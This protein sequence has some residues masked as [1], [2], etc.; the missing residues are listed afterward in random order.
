MRRF[1]VKNLAFVVAIN[2]PIRLAY[3]L[4]IDR[5]VQ[6]RVGAESYGTYSPLLSWTVIFSIILDFGITNY[7]SRTVAQNP[8]KLQEL[9][10]TMLSARLLL[11]MAYGAIVTI[12]GFVVGYNSYQML[13]LSGILVFQSLNYMLQFLRS[14]VAAL[15]KFKI[16]GILSIA[17][18]LLMIVVCG[19]L[20]L[21]PGTA[22][23]FKIEWYIL[24]QIGTYG[25]GCI[26][27]FFVLRW[28]HPIRFRFSFHGQTVWRII[29]DTIPYATLIFLMSIYTRLDSPMIER[30]AGG[31]GKIQAAIYA[32]AYRYLDMSNM[33]ALMFAAILLPMFG[34]MLKETQPVNQIVHVCVN[35]L[36]PFSF[37]VA[38][39]GIFF[40]NPIMQ[41]SFKAAKDYPDPLYY[42]HVF[43][44]TMAEFPAFCIMYI[45]STLLTANGSLKTLNKLAIG[46]VVF[47]LGLNLYIIPHY[48]AEGAAVVGC[49]TQWLIALG[50]IVYCIKEIKLK[51][52]VKLVSALVGYLALIVLLAAGVIFIPAPWLVQL[53]VFGLAASL[54]MF[55]FRFIS[56]GEIKKLVGKK[57]GV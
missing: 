35:T 18:R 51:A 49:L 10:P 5:V 29:K 56:V 23:H 3:V 33:F 4:F 14:N 21:Y 42:G 12:T 40:C 28:L 43:R 44:W 16:D 19:A 17:D 38:V 9:F 22:Q 8:D 32:A 55:P 46:A 7:N 45:Y 26:I 48:K 11:I 53:I 39:A 47:N 36:L 6:N 50:F 20:L 41:L 25:I 15:H 31:D 24:A 1:F 2:L 52:D 13:L 54:L 57:E 34:R 30:L 37:I 27:A